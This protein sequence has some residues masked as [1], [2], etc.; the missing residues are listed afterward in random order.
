MISSDNDN[1]RTPEQHRAAVAAWAAKAP[2]TDGKIFGR[3]AHPKSPRHAALAEEFRPL[4]SWIELCQAAEADPVQSTWL[5]DAA[6]SFEH[7][8]DD[9]TAPAGSP[10]EAAEKQWLPKS[11]TAAERLLTRMLAGVV[12]EERPERVR[13]TRPDRSVIHET[14]T[15]TVIVGGDVEFS[16]FSGRLIRAGDFLFNDGRLDSRREPANDNDDDDETVDRLALDPV[17]LDDVGDEITGDEDA[18]PDAGD[19]FWDAQVTAGSI[20]GFRHTFAAGNQIVTPLRAK[21]RFTQRKSAPPPPRDVLTMEEI[22][23]AKDR[24]AFVCARLTPANVALLDQYRAQSFEQIGTLLGKRG[25]TAERHA[26]SAMLMACEELATAL[27]E[28]DSIADQKIS[29]A[30]AA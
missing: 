13:H 28:Y 26:R 24:L 16:P 23:A 4:L 3:A 14:R 22:W 20:R 30:L 1:V 17:D 25:K 5:A 15:R 18:A 29:T 27:Q 7:E 21:L 8:N 6:L 9:D 10:V 2:A 19:L 12:T 11:R